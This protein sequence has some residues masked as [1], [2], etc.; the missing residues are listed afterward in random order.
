M[1]AILLDRYEVI[2]IAFIIQLHQVPRIFQLIF[3]TSLIYL[4]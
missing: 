2:K 1:S 3:L 4:S